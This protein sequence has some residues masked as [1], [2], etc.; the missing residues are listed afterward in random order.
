ME[1]QEFREKAKKRIDD[2]FDK[3]E[4]I[5]A[6]KDHAKAEAKEGYNKEIELLEAKK[7][8]LQH[9]YNALIDAA[10]DKWDEVKDAFSNSADSFKDAFSKLL[11][12][13]KKHEKDE[14]QELL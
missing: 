1:K 3:I 9:N 5:K 12:P 2:I 4:E 10:E 11:S 6:K 8:E 13:F 7:E 14:Q